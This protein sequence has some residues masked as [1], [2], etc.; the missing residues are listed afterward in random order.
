MYQ[1]SRL[2]QFIDNRLRDGGE[3]V[4]L[5]RRQIFML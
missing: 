2:P 1:A 4:S 5:T 3:V